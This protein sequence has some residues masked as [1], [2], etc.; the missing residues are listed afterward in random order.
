[1]LAPTI[2]DTVPEIEGFAL[3]RHDAH[4][5]EVDVHKGQHLND[6]FRALLG[7]RRRRGV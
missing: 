6:V 2:I 4:C 1:M 3:R 5:V 7:A